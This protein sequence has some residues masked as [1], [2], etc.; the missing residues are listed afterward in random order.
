MMAPS[1][2][3]SYKVF[4]PVVPPTPVRIVTDLLLD[5]VQP[6]ISMEDQQTSE[7]RHS[8]DNLPIW[9]ALP[10]LASSDAAFLTSSSPI[11]S[12]SMLPELPTMEISP[13]KPHQNQDLHTMK[14]KTV[15]ERR[16]EEALVKKHAEADILRAQVIHLQSAMVLQRLYC[17]RVRRQLGAKETKANKKAKKGGKLLSDGLPHLLTDDDFYERV[18]AHFEAQEAQDAEKEGWKQK[19]EDLTAEVEKWEKLEAEQKVRNKELDVRWKAAVEE[20]ETEKKEAKGRGEK[21]K[22][23]TQDNPKPK[24]ND[25][26]FRQEKAIPKPKL[27]KIVA[28][29]EPEQPDVEEFDSEEWCDQED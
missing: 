25:P 3:T 17:G 7:D 13:A 6:G 24:K 29:E 2:E 16:L 9:I 4:T 27:Q 20:W 15:I 19:K 1:R 8:P 22:N 23:W 11:K 28:E 21:I 10:Q 5:A 12:S 14:M 18:V 26:E